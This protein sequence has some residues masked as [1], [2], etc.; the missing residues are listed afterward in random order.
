[1]LNVIAQF[2]EDKDPGRALE[3]EEC[4][5]RNLDCPWVS[6]VHQ[7]VE[8]QTVLPE[9][10]TS[11]PKLVEQRVEGRL[12][13]AGAFAYANL[14]LQGKT[15]CLMNADTFVDPLSS[16]REIRD[17]D[18]RFVLCQSRHDLQADGSLQMS[19]PLIKGFGA[20]SQDAWIWRSPLS[21]PNADFELGR[22]GCDNAIAHR[23]KAAGYVLLNRGSVL[24]IGHIDRCRGKD[25]IGTVAYHTTHEGK[26]I[27]RPAAHGW[28]LVP[29]MH[30]VPPPE[31]LL[32]KLPS[33]ALQKYML[34]AE[35]LS[36][37]WEPTEEVIRQPETPA[38]KTREESSNKA[39]TNAA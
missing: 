20:V 36:T 9:W 5:R 13:Y 18:P 1:M 17:L 24:K 15:V 6:S 12:T 34:S 37:L 27:Q 8:A 28:A 23:F 30:L 35:I 14:H 7:L 26:D 39:K 22:L 29:D 3:L 10:A 33:S 2:Y 25:E 31:V 21:V 4:L 11:H 32:E 19:K 16:W 38:L